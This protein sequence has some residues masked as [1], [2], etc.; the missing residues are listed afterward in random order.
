MD[1]SFEGRVDIEALARDSRTE[2]YSGADLAALVREAGL[3]VVKEWKSLEPFDSPE[4]Q[5]MNAQDERRSKLEF[6]T[7]ISK[8]HFER[9]LNTVK[10]SVA[11]DDRKRFDE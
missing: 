8:R 4:L 10:P 5:N 1:E 11:S 6:T 7:K 3:A 9:A 2:G